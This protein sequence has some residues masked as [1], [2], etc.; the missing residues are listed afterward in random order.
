MS[1]TLSPVFP[2]PLYVLADS[3]RHILGSISRPAAF[4]SGVTMALRWRNE[5]LRFALPMYRLPKEALLAGI[6][7]LSLF[8]S[9]LFSLSL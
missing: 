5:W 8:V 9:L 6:F 7:A 3:D 4:K 1:E 2:P